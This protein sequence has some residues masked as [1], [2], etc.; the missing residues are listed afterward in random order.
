MR[1][2]VVLEQA[3]AP[4]P[5]GTG[6]YSREVAAALSA[7]APDGWG[8]QGWTA[9][10]CDPSPARIPGVA[11]PRRLPLGRRAL[12]A[13]WE[14]GRG[15]DVDADVVFA[16]TLL[17]PPARRAPLVVTV[18]DAVPWTHP[19]TLT[20]RGVAFHRRM[21]ARV[22]RQA[23]AVAVPTAAV[24]AELATVLPLREPPVVVGEGVAASLVPPPDAAARRRRLGVPGDG[25]LL[26]LATLEP[27]KGLDVALAALARPEAPPL[28]L[29][30][31]GRPGWGGVDP[32]AEAARLGLP[33]GRVRVLGALSDPDVAAVLA[34]A[35]ALVAPSRAEGFGLP[36]LEAMSLG[37]PVVS[38]DVPALAE[39]G[40]TATCRVP[41]GDP[42]A[43]AGALARV[44]ADPA[45]RAQLA[46]AGRRQAGR[47]S[48]ARTAELLWPVLAGAHRAARR[49]AP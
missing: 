1:V 39:V 36:V 3:L 48:W 11:G 26:S 30:L 8:V 2:G 38:S 27:R 23:A 41:V 46:A 33:P 32:Q 35:T 20:P 19:E 31:V 49:T 5:G 10:H 13:A 4:V 16:P 34:G 40:G 42:G 6:R 14:R 15:P 37:V 44:C 22:A 25:Y 24:A 45:W 9:W 43:L 12:A 18:H 47:Y 28:P 7:A 21:A 29:V 17:V